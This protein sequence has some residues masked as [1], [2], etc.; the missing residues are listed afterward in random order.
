[1]IA[2]GDFDAHQGPGSAGEVCPGGFFVGGNGGDGVGGVVRG[3]GDNGNRRAADFFADFFRKRPDYC[4]RLD[5]F[6]HNIRW[7]GS[8]FRKSAVTICLFAYP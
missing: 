1:M 5:D 8:V 4:S 3:D 7:A 2:F 6:G